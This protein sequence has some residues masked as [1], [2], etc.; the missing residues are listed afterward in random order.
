[1][2]TAI[3]L[4]NTPIDPKAFDAY[5]HSTHVPLAKRLPGLRTYRTSKGPVMTPAGPAPYH[6]VA[7]LSFGSMADVQV[8]LASTDGQAVVKDLSNFATGGV[9]VLLF[10][11]VEA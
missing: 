5:Y 8:A 1:M 11:D 9:T 3:A 4:Y 7:M 6:L 2:A 10:E